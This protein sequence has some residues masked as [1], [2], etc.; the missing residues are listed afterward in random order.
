M[1]SKLLG[2]KRG[3]GESLITKWLVHI[4]AHDTA[5]IGKIEISNGKCSQK[6]LVLT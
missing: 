1:I 3:G 2:E 6:C 5:T 4:W